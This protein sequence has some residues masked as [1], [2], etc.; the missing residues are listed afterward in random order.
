[1]KDRECAY[2]LHTNT[3]CFQAIINM[4]TLQNSVVHLINVMYI[5]SN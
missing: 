3:A 5:E 1:M 4:V 2:I